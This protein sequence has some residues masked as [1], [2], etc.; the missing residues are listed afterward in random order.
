MPKW[1]VSRRAAVHGIQ[2]ECP[3]PPRPGPLELGSRAR[4]VAE[5]YDG[6]AVQS[7]TTSELSNPCRVSGHHSEQLC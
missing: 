5:V 6:H 7:R 4:G 2:E 3:M 1:N